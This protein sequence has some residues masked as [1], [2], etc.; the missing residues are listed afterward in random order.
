MNVDIT[1]GV[2]FRGGPLIDVCISLLGVSNA[3]ELQGQQRR[4][5]LRRFLKGLTFKMTQPL[6]GGRV[7]V[8]KITDISRP[9][10]E[11]RFTNQEGEEITVVVRAIFWPSGS[12]VMP[13][14]THR[15]ILIV[16]DDHSNTQL[17]FVYKLARPNSSSPWSF[18]TSS[19]ANSLRSQVQMV[20]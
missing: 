5:I 13:T 6:R 20:T 17:F 19:L 18:V 8:Y 2:M 15:T 3:R 12:M 16:L 14:I 4:D 10:S 7:K 1:T 11:I 9:A